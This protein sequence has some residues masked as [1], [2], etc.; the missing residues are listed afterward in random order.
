[1]KT[2]WKVL[3]V[4]GYIVAGVFGINLLYASFIYAVR[5]EGWFPIYNPTFSSHSN[6]ELAWQAI[7]SIIP[8]LLSWGLISLSNKKLKSV[9]DKPK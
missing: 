5:H 6:S 2:P 9:G 3:K 1:M 7:Y 4:V 8:V